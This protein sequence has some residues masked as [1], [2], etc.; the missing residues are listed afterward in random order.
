M[1]NI[2]EIIYNLQLQIKNLE[3]RME[4]EEVKHKDAIEKLQ[5]K[6]VEHEEYMA[7][8]LR[9]LDYHTLLR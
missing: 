5:R 8:K 9:V 7:S 1:S 6:L 2:N 3:Q 4:Q